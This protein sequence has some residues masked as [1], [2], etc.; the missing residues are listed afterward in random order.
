MTRDWFSQ[1]QAAAQGPD[2]YFFATFTPA[3]AERLADH[4][5]QHPLPGFAPYRVNEGPCV[6]HRHRSTY[7]LYVDQGNYPRLVANFEGDSPQNIW[8]YHLIEICGHDLT[9][10]RGYGGYPGSHGAT[11]T[12]LILALARTPD[13]TLTDWKIG[14]AGE[15]YPTGHVATGTTAAELLAYLQDG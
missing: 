12:T 5:R 7:D 1:I 10:A 8:T 4:V 9:I 13:L 3:D 2:W 6:R 15:G 11:E 14:Y